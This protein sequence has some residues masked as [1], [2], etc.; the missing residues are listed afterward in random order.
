MC[1]NLQEYYLRMYRQLAKHYDKIYSSKDYKSECDTI[2]FLIKEFKKSKGKEMLDVACGTG[3]HIQYLKK[4]YNITGIDLDKEMLK[5]AKKKIPDIIFY[6]GD[7]RSFELK[8]QF[9]VIV[10]LG[11]AISKMTNKIQLRQTIKNF[12]MHLKH[13]GIM[14]LEAFITP[15]TFKPN[16]FH[17]VYINEPELKIFR[18]AT[19]KRKGNIALI[20]FHVLVADKKGVKYITEN[21]KLAMYE[22][23]DFLDIMENEGLKSTYDTRKDRV[24][25]SRGRYIGI[26]D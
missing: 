9:D 13:G 26:K 24:M 5:V 2:H 1:G 10:C 20:D 19:T 3:N 21:H 4:Y 16:L 22:H 25:A 12:S 17:S 8:K 6:Q 14:I 11:A 7:M 23:K 18:V 15:D